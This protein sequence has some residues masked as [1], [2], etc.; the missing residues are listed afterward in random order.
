MAFFKSVQELDEL[1]GFV[2]LDSREPPPETVGYL[3]AMLKANGKSVLN[4]GSQLLNMGIVN[5][6][7]ICGNPYAGH[8]PGGEAWKSELIERHVPA[9][10]IHFSI[11]PPGTPEHTYSASMAFV[12]KAKEMGWKHATIT[13]APFHQVR[14]FV[15]VV[16]ATLRHYPELTLYSRPGMDQDMAER[17]VYNQQGDTT[18]RMTS[19]PQ[20]WDRII[21]YHANVQGDLVSAGEVVEY[22]K[23]R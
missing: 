13:A 12:H 3:V 23:R 14:A 2:Y 1:F 11:V 20:E 15:S 21:T 17:C 22:M 4:R 5:A 10:L 16:S 19:I 7:C 18:Y 6:L 8:Y 9:D